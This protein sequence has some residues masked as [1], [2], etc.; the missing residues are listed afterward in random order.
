M[1]QANKDT[2][3]VHKYFCEYGSK[4]FLFLGRKHLRLFLEFESLE[5]LEFDS[6][7]ND[8]SHGYLFY[9]KAEL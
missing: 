5:A 3:W 9:E 4:G 6:Y 8:F 1:N 2:F 7:A